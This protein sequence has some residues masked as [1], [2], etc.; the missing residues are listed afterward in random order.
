M[1]EWKVLLLSDDVEPL[2]LWVYALA[3]RHIDAVVADFTREQP[4]AYLRAPPDIVIFDV[5]SAW[6]HALNVC[7]E[8][9]TQLVNPI[10]MLA[11]ISSE[12][13]MVEAYEAGV[14]ECIAKP[15]GLRLLT[16]KVRAWLRRAWT[17]PTEALTVLDVGGLRLNPEKRLVDLPDGG[18]IPLTNLELRLLHLLTSHPGQ[19]LKPSTMI[20]RV[21]GYESAEGA[22]LKNMVYRLRR[23]IEPDPAHPQYIRTVDGGYVY[24]KK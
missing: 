23:K 21:W 14:D 12:P 18:Q 13:Q 22:V 3:K 19:V 6:R 5:S 15:I 11:Y 7:R 17:V 24:R 20:D 1:P 10:L 2:G 8:L 9:R 4:D 16:A